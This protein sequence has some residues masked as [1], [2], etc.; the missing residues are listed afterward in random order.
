MKVLLTGSSGFLGGYLVEELISHGYEVVGIDNFSKYGQIKKSYDD[1]PKYKFIQ[2]D[3]K[4]VNL[5]KEIASDCDQVIAAAAMIGG[6]TYFHEFAYDLLAENER[7]LASTFDGAISSFNSGRTKKITVISSSMVFESANLYPT[8][9][10]E[11]LNSPPPKST[12]GFQKLSSEYYAKGAFEQYGLPYTIIRPFNCIGTG[13]GRALSDKEVFSGNI[14]L[15]MSHVL[16]DLIQKILKGQNPVH[17]LGNGNQIRHYTHGKDL[18]RGIRLSMEIDS[19]FNNDF[20]LSTSRSTSV[21]ELAKIVWNQIKGE[22]EFKYQLEAGFKYD[23]QKRMP[24]TKKAKELLGFE[25][26]ISLEDGV[27]EVIE[28]IKDQ[29]NLGNM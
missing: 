6:I 17:L 4:D 20:N 28:W 22:E 15:A 12:Y 27:K 1:H 8:P 13:E 18:A 11:V 5:M 9:E 25:A 14:K 16:P 7:I 21:I 26:E 29:I 2:G 10:S 23:V 24:C 19:S 3:C